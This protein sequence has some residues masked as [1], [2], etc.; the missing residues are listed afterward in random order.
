MRICFCLAILAKSIG[1]HWDIFDDSLQLAQLAQR[2]QVPVPL[3][4][5]QIWEEY[6]TIR[7]RGVKPPL[8]HHIDFPKYWN[9]LRINWQ[10]YQSD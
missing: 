2:R 4:R 10:D 1:Y 6:K 9:K 5:R 8:P 3:L 7:K